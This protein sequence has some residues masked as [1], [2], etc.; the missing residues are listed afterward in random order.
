MGFVLGVT[1]A[2][3]GALIAIGLILVFRLVPARVVG[4]DIFHAAILLWVAAGAHI[5]GEC[6]LP[7]RGQYP[8]RVGPGGMG[9]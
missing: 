9:W 1:S 6:G 4:T 2:G 8:H 5:V 3:S 7:P